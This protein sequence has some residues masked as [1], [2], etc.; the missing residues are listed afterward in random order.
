MYTSL[1]DLY[2]FISSTFNISAFQNFQD[3]NIFNIAT[4]PLLPWLPDAV[5]LGACVRVKMR[6]RS[7]ATDD[8]HLSM[9]GDEWMHRCRLPWIESRRLGVQRRVR[10]IFD[11]A[12]VDVCPSPAELVQRY[13]PGA[14]KNLV[15]DECCRGGPLRHI[16]FLCSCATDFLQA[17]QLD[18]EPRLEGCIHSRFSMR[19]VLFLVTTEHTQTLTPKPNP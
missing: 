14:S 15:L 16:R 1:R 3:F 19:D 9:C 7:L 2:H 6:V 8:F 11:V 17:L 18:W 5:D 10:R 12:P 4:S 13:P